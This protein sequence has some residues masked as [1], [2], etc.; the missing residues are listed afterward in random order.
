MLFYFK[1]WNLS[2]YLSDVR[3]WALGIL[4]LWAWVEERWKE[5]VKG[6]WLTARA[7]QGTPKRQACF[8]EPE[9]PS[10]VS[11]KEAFSQGVSDMRVCVYTDAFLCL[12]EPLPTFGRFL[13]LLFFPHRLC[14]LQYF[15][16][17]LQLI[18]SRLHLLRGGCSWLK[19]G[20]WVKE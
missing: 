19:S 17:S 20:Q 14:Q 9:W 5:T 3:K 4:E 8:Q 7:V 10:E 1:R 13:M 11:V 6:G 2:K 15:H 12:Y 16:I 18:H